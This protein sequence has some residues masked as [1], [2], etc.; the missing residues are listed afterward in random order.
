MKDTFDLRKFLTE[1]KITTASQQMLSEE[2]QIAQDTVQAV[3]VLAKNDF[4]TKVS[5]EDLIKMGQWII[6][7]GLE[8]EGEGALKKA[9]SA[10]KN[11][12]IEKDLKEMAVYKEPN[13]HYRTTHD[14][15]SFFTRHDA[16]A[17]DEKM[18][19]KMYAKEVAAACKL[20]D[21]SSS[22]SNGDSK[23]SG[24]PTPEEVRDSIT[25]LGVVPLG[26]TSAGGALVAIMSPFLDKLDLIHRIEWGVAGIAV[27][28]LSLYGIHAYTDYTEKVYQAA[29]KKNQ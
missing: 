1:N 15:R 22:H 29:K 2:E 9:Y 28:L 7:H 19:A 5:E 4:L 14:N 12:D 21:N 11:G 24:P 16:E 6:L 17:H 18:K 25:T 13:S 26:L 20:A 23:P 8:G 10:I 27:T 3:K